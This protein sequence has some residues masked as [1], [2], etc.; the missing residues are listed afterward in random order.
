MPTLPICPHYHYLIPQSS[1][2]Q[3]AVGQDTAEVVPEGYLPRSNP[4]DRL[5]EASPAIWIT[6]HLAASREESLGMRRHCPGA[7]VGD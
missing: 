7:C 1:T 5:E 6:L 4:F 2:F 3:A